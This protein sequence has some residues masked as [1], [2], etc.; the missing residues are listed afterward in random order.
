MSRARNTID[1]A[2]VVESFARSSGPGGQHVNKTDSAV[3]IT[4]LPT[5]IVVT[6]QNERS[7]IQ[8]REVALKLLKVRLYER[9]EKKREE[10]AAKLK[11]EHVQ[12]D[13]GTQIRSVTVHPYTIVKDHRTNYETSDTEGYLNGNVDP[14]IYAYLQMKAGGVATG[15]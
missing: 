3:R 4:H 15:A 9:E 1:P 6:C 14:F 8:N 7:Q 5:G 11:G 2:D 13:F 10:E 12:A